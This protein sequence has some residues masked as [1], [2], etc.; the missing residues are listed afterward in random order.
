MFSI[1]EPFALIVD[2][3]EEDPIF[4]ERTISDALLEKN[5]LSIMTKKAKNIAH[6]NE[7]IGINID[8]KSKF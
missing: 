4:A 7:I 1:R 3:S 8:L 2:S 5:I 6:T